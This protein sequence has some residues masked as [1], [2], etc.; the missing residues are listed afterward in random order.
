MLVVRGLSTKLLLCSA[1]T[2][3]VK[4]FMHTSRVV[5]VPIQEVFDG[6]SQAKWRLTNVTIRIDK[7]RAHT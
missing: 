4:P 7:L 2:L 1:C 5:C 3:E 6:P